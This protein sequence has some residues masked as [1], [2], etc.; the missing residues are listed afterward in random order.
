MIRLAMLNIVRYGG[1]LIVI[2]NV[3]W[4]H[5]LIAPTIIVCPGPSRM[6]ERK[7]TA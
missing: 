6:S 4:V 2:R 1:F 5:A 3:H 7:S